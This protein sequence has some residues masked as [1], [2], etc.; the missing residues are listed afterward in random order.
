MM[1]NNE[2]PY[3]AENFEN[4]G[5]MWRDYTVRY[6]IIAAYCICRRYLEFQQNSPDESEREFCRQLQ[7]AM[8]SEQTM[9]DVDVYRRS[10]GFAELD[11]DMYSY[12]KSHR[13]NHQCAGDIDEAIN[14]CSY[15]DGSVDYKEALTALIAR[16]G[17]E[18]LRFVLSCELNWDSLFGRYPTE[19]YQWAKETNIHE[20]YS[21]FGVRTRPEYL[22][23]LI[24]EFRQEEQ[25]KGG[26]KL[27][28]KI[29]FYI[30][31]YEQL[32]L[33]RFEAY[34]DN[35]KEHIVEICKNG[36]TVAHLTKADTIEPNP[37]AEV[38]PGTI[39]TLREIFKNT[40][41]MCGLVDVRHYFTETDLSVIHANLEKVR[42]MPD[43]GLDSK[44]TADIDALINKI[45]KIAPELGGFTADFECAAVHDEEQGVEQ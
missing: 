43:S 29:D 23:G 6:G 36:K 30:A 24:T 28:N 22:A 38:D 35:S 3:N 21:K 27:R 37:H 19:L 18:R 33:K 2:L 11:G 26:P 10:Q 40:M 41:V 15:G 44:E 8:K 34:A 9:I 17:M 31:F 5:A 25:N 16:Y 45:E 14:A 39:D 1:A 42:M 13:A 4:G 7:D 12:D 20:S 32:A